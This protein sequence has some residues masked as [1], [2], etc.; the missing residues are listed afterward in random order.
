MRKILLLL[1]LFISTTLI[2]QTV[3]QWRGPERN[4][5]YPETGLLKEWPTEGPVKLWVAKDLGMGYSSAAVTVNLIYITGRKGEKEVLTALDL[6]GN[7]IWQVEFGRA[8]ED[9]YPDT[10]TTP[11]VNDGKVYLISGMGEVACHDAKTGERIWMRDAFQEFSG[12]CN[13]YGISEAPLVMGNK[14]FYTPGGSRTSMIALDKNTGALLWE[15]PALGDSAAYVS[16]LWVTHNEQDQIINLMGNWAF[17]V[18]PDTGKILWKFDYIA[19]PTDQS[20]PYMIRTNCNTPIY[21]QGCVFLNKGYDH[22]SAMLQLDPAGKKVDLKWTN[23]DLDT[24]MGGA[25][26]V[27]GYLYG[28]N[29]LNNSNGNWVCVDW[30]TG[31]TQWETPW[32]N[33]GA[34]I[35]GDGMLYCYEEK[36]GNI[37][38]V[39]PN[40]EK[41]DQVSSFKVSDGTGPH[42]SHPVIREGVLYI[43]HGDAIVAYLIR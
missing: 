32:N 16:P 23:K 4:G 35:Y 21:H 11:T 37:A 1:S 8:W 7:Q 5:W 14:V 39:R 25:V 26:L 33:K 34:I 41:F 40:P 10:R 30:E 9:A 2:S 12:V 6:Q 42:W 28:S 38:L 43:R 17:G 13:L 36:R 29:W 22:P 19:L 31:E 24:H 27:D 3:S 15:S 18:N 20:N